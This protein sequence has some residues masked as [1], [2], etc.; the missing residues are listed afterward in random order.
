[1]SSCPEYCT[2]V[3]SKYVD[4]EKLSASCSL[5]LGHQI[6]TDTRFN[7]EYYE[8]R[9]TNFYMCIFKEP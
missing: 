1:M 5:N 9:F 3:K 4:T 7:N 2:S 8:W 6:I